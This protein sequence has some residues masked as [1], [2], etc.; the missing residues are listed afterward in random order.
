MGMRALR[1]LL[2]LGGM[3]LGADRRARVIGRGGQAQDPQERQS[4][5]D[6]QKINLPEYWI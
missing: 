6:D 2:N 1:L 4:Y 5:R 3:T